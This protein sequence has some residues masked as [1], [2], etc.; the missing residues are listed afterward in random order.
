[1]PSMLDPLRQIPLAVVDVET[2]GASPRWGDRVIEIGIVRYEQGLAVRE[3]SA[4]IDPR[5]RI[6]AGITAL[7]GISHAMVE[8]QPTFAQRLREI[9]PMLSGAIVVGH[10]VRFD[11]G[12]L[13]SEFRRAG[14]P[15]SEALC[16][17]GG[18][19]L[20]TPHVLDTVRIARRRF[21][22]GGNALQALS[23]RLG[24]FPEVAHRALADA[25]TTGMVLERLLEPIGGFGSMLVDV[26]GAQ[27]GTMP[28]EPPAREPEPLPMEILDAIEAGREVRMIYL[29]REARRS[30]RR[31][32]PLRIRRRRGNAMLIAHCHLR[33][34]Q[35]SFKLDRIVTMRPLEPEGEPGLFDGPG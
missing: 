34:E 4:L 28:L 12:F 27:G 32:L 31:I 7:T 25:R 35:R 5:R 8:G 14:T 26:L 9:V 1:M 3:F 24:V 6:S 23:R 15:F 33:N 29:D 19:R 22:R 11:L 30:E 2:T 10:N 13:S 18:A 17:S 16:E 21:G 20:P